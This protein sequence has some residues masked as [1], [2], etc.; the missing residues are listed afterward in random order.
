MFFLGAAIHIIQDMTIPQHAN[1]RLLDNHHQYEIYVNCTY[2]Y[3]DKLEVE[4]GALLQDSI[5]DYIRFNARVAIKIYKK[6]NMISDD[7]ERFYRIAKCG[8]L[9]R[10]ELRRSYG[11]VL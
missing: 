4:K 8:F 6:F 7:D 2:E 3:L 5:E 11:Y 1:I 10:R 9:W